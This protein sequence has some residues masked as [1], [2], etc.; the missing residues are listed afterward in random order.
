VVPIAQTR[1]MRR[2][3]FVNVGIDKE[4]LSKS[5]GSFIAAFK[6]LMVAVQAVSKFMAARHPTHDKEPQVP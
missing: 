3:S 4:E 2:A 1:L 5:R 6:I